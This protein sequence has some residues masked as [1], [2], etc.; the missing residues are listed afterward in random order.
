MAT[1]KDDT[2]TEGQADESAVTGPVQEQVDRE[3]ERGYRGHKVDPT[4]DE[5]YTLAGQ[6]AGAPTPETD[7]DAREAARVARVE[8]E[9]KATGVAER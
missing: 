7:E 8:A 1:R 9:Q 5:N 6:V 3:T 2:K 4:P